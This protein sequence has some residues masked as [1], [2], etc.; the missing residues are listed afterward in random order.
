MFKHWASILLNPIWRKRQ[1]LTPTTLALVIILGPLFPTA[2]ASSQGGAIPGTGVFYA[3]DG[4]GGIA[5]LS[6]KYQWRDSWS[7][8]I[9]GNFGGNFGETDDSVTDLL[10]YDRAAGHG[11]FY[12]TDGNGN[13]SQLG[14]THTG[15]RKTWDIIVP[16]NISG[17][18][19]YRTDL[20]FY[21]R[22]AGHGEIYTTDGNG[23]ISQLGATHTGWRK[24]WDIIVSIGSLSGELLFYDRAAGHGEFFYVSSDGGI[25]QYGVTHTDWR[26]TWD[27]IVYG[28]WQLDL[29]EVQSAR[30][31]LFYDRAAGHGE[32][33]GIDGDFNI[34]QAGPTQRW[35]K[36]WDIIVH[37]RFAPR[38]FNGEVFN[39]PGLFFYD[40]V[41]GESE[42]Y[43]VYPDASLHQI[44]PTHTNWR[45]ENWSQ[46]IPGNFNHFSYALAGNDGFDDLLFYGISLSSETRLCPLGQVCCERE[47]NV[48]LKCRPKEA[49][50]E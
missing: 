42:I 48:C 16:I 31:L 44:G 47:G 34:I 22:A 23:N 43:D 5:R 1:I 45:Q 2:P 21:D 49:D 19:D 39:L 8:I 37:G 36:T 11:E 18:G 13:I 38:Y 27:V 6:P 14:A 15:W 10:F 41:A 24:T 17:S 7:L 46:I 20:L 12:T 25:W 40:R 50:C 35:R 26:K 9:P 32:F 3:T 29:D 28:D 4:T 30:S 33:Y